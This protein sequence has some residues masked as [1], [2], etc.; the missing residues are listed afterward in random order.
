VAFEQLVQHVYMVELDESVAAVW[1][2]IL[3]GGAEWLGNRILSYQLDRKQVETDL[4]QEP[5]DLREKAFL[6]LVRNRVCRGGILAPGTGL[7]EYGEKGKGV[8]SRWYPATLRRRILDIASV[9]DR[10]TFKP[11]DA[12]E[13]IESFKERRDAVFFIDPPYTASKKSAGNRLYNHSRIDHK[14]LFELVA[15][16][17]GDLLLTY[18]NAEEVKTLAKQVGLD[19]RTV[20]MKNTHHAEMAELLIGRN[21]DWLT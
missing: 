16:C 5:S 11:G 19:T 4:K 21:F 20:A 13:C 14:A 18:D 3:G 17:K 12:F 7:I 2:M 1:E 10:M 15:K 6:T 9:R 8:H